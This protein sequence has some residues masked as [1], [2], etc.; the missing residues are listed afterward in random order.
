M[1]TGF[2]FLK[3]KGKH[4]NKQKR[5]FCREKKGEEIELGKSGDPKKIKLGCLICPVETSFFSALYPVCHP[6]ECRLGIP[7]FE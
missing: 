3:R 4:R 1:M 7:W 6:Y 5:R 2:S